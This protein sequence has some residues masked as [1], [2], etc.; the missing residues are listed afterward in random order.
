MIITDFYFANPRYLL[1][2]IILPIIIY[3]LVIISKQLQATLKFPSTD[4]LKQNRT[5]IAKIRPILYVLRL[6][7]IIFIII[8][9]ARPQTKE[10]STRIK[11]TRGIDIAA[12]TQIW[13]LISEFTNEGGSVIVVSNEIPE[14]IIN[15][16]RIITMQKGLISNKFN[17]EDFNE[18]KI[19]LNI[20]SK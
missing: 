4:V 16:N 10:T 7:A 19:S 2:L 6:F 13:K 18:Q 5:N 17:H 12:K 11:T 20:S 8:S 15:C 1:L 9:L 3:Y 14:L